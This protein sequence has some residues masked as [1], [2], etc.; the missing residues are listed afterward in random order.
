MNSELEYFISIIQKAFHKVKF[1]NLA[2]KK[3]K[4]VF[5]TTYS[6]TIKTKDN[7]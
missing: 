4:I 1:R 7:F 3:G 6:R 2:K 5:I